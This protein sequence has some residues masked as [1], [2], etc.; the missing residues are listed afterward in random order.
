MITLQQL[1]ESIT[2]CSTAQLVAVNRDT[3]LPE[4][5]GCGFLFSDKDA[6]LVVTVL[7]NALLRTTTI[8][9]GLESVAGTF[10]M[11]N[12]WVHGFHLIESTKLVEDANTGAPYIDITFAEIPA[13]EFYQRWSLDFMNGIE[14]YPLR[15]FT[16][17]DIL[18]IDDK[19][20]RTGKYSFCANVEPR[21]VDVDVSGPKVIATTPLYIGDLMFADFDGDY[22]LRF[23]TRIP[24]CEYGID[25]PGSSGAP[26]LD[27]NGRLVALVCGGDD[28][29]DRAVR[30]VRFDAIVC[31]LKDQTLK[32][33]DLERNRSITN[34]ASVLMGLLD[35][36]QRKF[37][38]DKVDKGKII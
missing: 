23:L 13:N 28:S 22:Y 17:A 37:Y 20:I 25:F 34:V 21:D 19:N 5:W 14:Q 16:Q 35:A 9:G 26:I 10:A 30:A 1:R 15:R 3:E 18:R 4:G 33:S 31:G 27:E 11:R 29:N 38:W 7:H 6:L 12:R 36:D 32:L 8:Q 24:L 2:K